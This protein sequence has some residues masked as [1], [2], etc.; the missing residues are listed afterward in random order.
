[1]IQN[2]SKYELLHS[3]KCSAR[4]EISLT[5]ANVGSFCGIKYTKP[6]QYPALLRKQKFVP[7][8]GCVTFTTP[9][10]R[11]AAGS[12]VDSTQYYSL[13]YHRYTLEKTR[14]SLFFTATCCTK[15]KLALF[16]C[17]IGIN[18]PDL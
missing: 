16:M 4:R 8:I 7:E 18:V 17:I 5:Q 9:C 14:K 12:E 2:R 15:E 13:H 6:T 10:F 1:M 11:V 3:S